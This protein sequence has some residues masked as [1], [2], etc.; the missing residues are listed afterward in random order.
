MLEGLARRSFFLVAG[1][2]LSMLALLSPRPAN[3][4]VDAEIV[5]LNKRFDEALVT[6]KE[7]KQK[8]KTGALA[9]F[10]RLAAKAKNGKGGASVK[11][12][13]VAEI[14]RAR[15]EFGDNG[16]FTTDPEFMPLQMRYYQ[17]INKGYRPLARIQ[18]QLL[19][20]ALKTNDDKLREG[21]QKKRKAL[22]AE[23]PG[24][25]AFAAGSHWAGTLALTNGTTDKMKLHIEKLTGSVF[26]AR[27]IEKPSTANH[28][29]YLAEGS[30]EGLAVKFKLNKVIQGSTII[31]SF[32]G[33]LAGDQL[34]GTLDQASNRG[35]RSSGIV[36]LSL[37]K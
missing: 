18:D 8:S 11:S 27:V 12:D 34:I 36:S 20:M 24:L 9:G 30:L 16:T 7:A 5:A 29:E 33:I 31:A 32:N 19:D 14:A 15:K 35:K 13:K 4:Q 6:F 28:P 3:A 1:L 25:G 37:G 22:E 21:V 17:D 23:L 2:S 26:R 10:D